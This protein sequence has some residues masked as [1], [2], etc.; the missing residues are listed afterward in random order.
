LLVSLT[1][2]DVSSSNRNDLL[3]D[4]PLPEEGGYSLSLSGIAPQLDFSRG[5]KVYVPSPHGEYATETD[6]FLRTV[7]LNRITLQESALPFQVWTCILDR[8][9]YDPL[10]KSVY[11]HR[12]LR[13]FTA[14]P[15][16]ILS[17]M[18][19]CEKESNLLLK[20]DGSY[21]RI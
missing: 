12:R 6:M 1:P 9:V 17:M 7:Q 13:I 11:L 8:S 20:N 21:V 14:F 5:L 18:V 19:Q 2:V 4:I 3:V 10:G 16:P 15:N